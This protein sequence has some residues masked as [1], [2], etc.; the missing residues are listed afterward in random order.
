MIFKTNTKY[1]M[2]NIISLSFFYIVTNTTNSTI[3][4]NALYSSYN[5]FVT[6][7]NDLADSDMPSVNILRILNYAQIELITLQKINRLCEVKKKCSSH[8]KYLYRK[9]ITIT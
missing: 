9:G 3:D 2:N 8:E 6:Y 1:K 4:E 5:E 7:V